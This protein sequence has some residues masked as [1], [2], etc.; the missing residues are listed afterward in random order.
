MTNREKAIEALMAMAVNRSKPQ[1]GRGILEL[2]DPW[3]FFEIEPRAVEQLCRRA[4]AEVSEPWEPQ[5]DPDLL[6][7]AASLLHEGWSP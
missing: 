1:G 7:A 6:A 4:V 5:H 3:W 2:P